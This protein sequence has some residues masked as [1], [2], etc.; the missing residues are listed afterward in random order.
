MNDNKNEKFKKK[1]L[2]ILITVTILCIIFGSIS[3]LTKAIVSFAGRFAGELGLNK[4]LTVNL[5]EVKSGSSS[6]QTFDSIKV[7]L[8]VGELVIKEGDDYSYSYTF[9]EKI[10]PEIEVKNGVLIV[11]QDSVSI[12]GNPKGIN[13]SELVITVPKGSNLD[14]INIVASMGNVKLKDISG[15]DM[16][17]S[18]SMGNIDVR[19]CTFDVTKVHNSMGDTIMT[20]ADI[21]SVSCANSMGDIEY[22]GSFDKIDLKTS[23]GKVEVNGESK[24][25]SYKE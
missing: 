16:E 10:I 14:S 6:L 2:G 20:N 17:T 5:G 11:K 7:K 15:K 18:L 1:Y 8:S 4:A 9:N 23:M 12:T 25:S 19:N 24:G 21:S 22:N 13:Q 3:N